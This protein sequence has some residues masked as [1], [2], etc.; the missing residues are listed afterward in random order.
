MHSTVCVYDRNGTPVKR[1]RVDISISG[2]LGGGMAH[3]FTDSTGCANIPHSSKGSA[4]VYVGGKKVATFTA[5]G[6]TSVTI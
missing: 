4:N 6:R 3:G 1:K 5:P 2:V